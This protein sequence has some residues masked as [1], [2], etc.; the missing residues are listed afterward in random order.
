M[1]E[2]LNKELSRTA[3][4]KGGGALVVRC[5]ID[6]VVDV[7]TDGSLGARDALRVAAAV[8]RD[9]EH[10][11]AQG[12][13]KSAE[14]K[15]LSVPK[16]DLFEAIPG[17]GVKAVVDGKDFY[18]GGPAMLKRL[19]LT[20]PAAVREAAERA[21]APRGRRC[22]HLGSWDRFARL[23]DL[24]IDGL[25]ANGWDAFSAEAVDVLGA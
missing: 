25:P 14:E 18:M 2:M 3:F 13:V 5:E 20:P 21:G 10:T 19:A 17:H 4:L 6:G 22:A 16:A 11:I 12:I 8:E 9:S 7:A 15:N 23:E 1:T 24:V